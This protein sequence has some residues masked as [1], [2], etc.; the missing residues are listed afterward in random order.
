MKMQTTRLLAPLYEA[1]IINL[2]T[3][4]KEI[5]IKGYQKCRSRKLSSADLW[6]IQRRQKSRVQRRFI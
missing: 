3:E 1:D 6:D 2:T 5:L 4:V